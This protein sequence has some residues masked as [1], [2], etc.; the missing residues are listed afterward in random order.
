MLIK[1]SISPMGFFSVALVGKTAGIDI[2]CG[3]Y[4]LFCV[5]INQTVTLLI[6]IGAKLDRVHLQINL[7]LHWIVVDNTIEVILS[8]KDIIRWSTW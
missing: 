5:L 8:M 6:E 2:H 7:S 1:I 3:F 4:L